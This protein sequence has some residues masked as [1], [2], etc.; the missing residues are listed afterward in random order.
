MTSVNDV[1]PDFFISGEELKKSAIE[2]L[3]GNYPEYIEM[4]RAAAREHG[5]HNETVCSDDVWAKCPPPGWAHVNVMGA[6]FK[7]DDFI[8]LGYRKSRRPSA[9]ARVISYYKLREGK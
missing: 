8:H 5:R 3:K 2:R 9:H 1:H 7:H 6:I 4:A